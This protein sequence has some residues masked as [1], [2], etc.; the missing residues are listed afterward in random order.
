MENSTNQESNNS[1][2]ADVSSEVAAYRIMLIE[3]EQRVSEQFDKTMLTIAGGALA[4]SLAFIKDV[5]G[6]GIMQQGWLLIFSWG[7]LTSCLI[8]ILVSFYLGLLAYRKAQDQVDEKTIEREVPGGHYSKALSICNVI[9]IF[10][11]CAGLIALFTFA[12]NN[13]SKEISNGGK[14]NTET[15]SETNAQTGSGSDPKSS[16]TKAV[17]LGFAS[18]ATETSKIGI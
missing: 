5:I 16:T 14:T 17:N 11:L 8:L 18:S 9:S 10:L 2:K 13:L 6:D 7:C 12:Y 1:G 4:I 3:I 15:G